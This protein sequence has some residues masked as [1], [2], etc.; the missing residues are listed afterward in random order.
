ME[1]LEVEINDAWPRCAP[2]PKRVSTALSAN[3]DACGD[4]DYLVSRNF[5]NHRNAFGSRRIP[6][7][8]RRNPRVCSFASAR[9][10]LRSSPPSVRLPLTEPNPNPNPKPA[11]PG[12]PRCPATR[13]RAARR[14]RTP[15]AR[16]RMPK[17]ASAVAAVR[18]PC[19]QRASGAGDS[20]TTCS[21]SF[22][23]WRSSR[24]SK[25]DGV[26]QDPEEA[27]QAH[28]RD[29]VLPILHGASAQLAVG[30]R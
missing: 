7:R 8:E 12:A 18:R 11:R 17:K 29:S 16:S 1:E 4:T 28:S 20:C 3:D 15:R 25:H 24:T 2:A 19:G 23:R 30:H 26:L 21:V 14:A 10:S 27:R 5:R 6:S 9:A 22:C 13:S